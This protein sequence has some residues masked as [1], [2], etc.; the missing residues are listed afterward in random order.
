MLF[1]KRLILNPLR[2]SLSSETAKNLKPMSYKERSFNE[3]Q[4]IGRVGEDPKVFANETD[5]TEN[6]VKTGKV[7]AFSLATDEFSGMSEQNEPRYRTDWHRV[8][9]FLPSLQQTVETVI[10]K[11]DRV[12]VSGSLKYKRVKL[13]NDPVERVLSNIIADNII[14]LSKFT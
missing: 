3:V 9:V 10:R 5:A 11:G 6:S 7:I 2:R 8:T 4:L 13:D 12:F 1:I 14:F